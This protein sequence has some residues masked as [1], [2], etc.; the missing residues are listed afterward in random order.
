[1]SISTPRKKLNM[2]FMHIH[3]MATTINSNYQCHPP[4]PPLPSPPSPVGPNKWQ[5]IIESANDKSK[6]QKVGRAKGRDREMVNS[7]G[8]GKVEQC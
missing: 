8:D 5:R 4:P 6:L 2:Y 3:V 1:M 7:I